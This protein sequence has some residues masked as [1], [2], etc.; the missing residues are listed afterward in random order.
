MTT[1][2]DIFTI[3]M[4]REMRSYLRSYGYNFNRKACEF[5]VNRMKRTNPATGKKEAIE[6]L[7]KENVEEMLRKHG[8]K[9]ENNE[10]HNFVY[11]A[12]MVKADF[13]KSSIEDEAHMAKMVKDIIDDP[14]NPGGNLFRKWLADADALGFVIDWEEIL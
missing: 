5:A 4:P 2:L 14:D 3:D 12:N 13:W 11:A 7:S 8:I 1:P 10:G 9:I 6:P